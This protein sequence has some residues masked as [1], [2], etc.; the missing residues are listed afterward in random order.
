[1]KINEVVLTELFDKSYEWDWFQKM[2]TKMIASFETDNETPIDVHFVHASRDHDWVFFFGV[3]EVKGVV[4]N[5]AINLEEYDTAK[6]IAT[7]IDVIKNFIQSEQ[8]DQLKFSGKN[9][10]LD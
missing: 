10:L 6:I 2:P 1:M 5:P 7:V 8:P 3:S 4:A 9:Q